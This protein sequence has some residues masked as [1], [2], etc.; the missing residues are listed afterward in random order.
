MLE[1]VGAERAILGIIM[2][3]PDCLYEV[4]DILD[5]SDFTNSGSKVIFSLMRDLIL[6]GAEE[7]DH[8]SLISAAEEKGLKDF[9]TL[10][11]EGGLLEAL[12]YTK[13]SV[14]V[15]TLFRHVSAV[16]TASIKR[17]LLET[18]DTLKDEVEDF[19]GD[20]IDLK[21]KV[22]SNIIDSIKV[23]DAG[24]DDIECLADNFEETINEYADKNAILGLNIDLPRWQRDC[25]GIKNGTVTGIFARAKAGK[26]QM[27]AY[28][29]AK[30]AIEQRLPILYLD[31]ELQL[32]HQQM[33]VAGILTGIKYE[34]I[35]SGA[36]KSDHDEIQQLKD[37]FG[38]VKASPFY[39]KNIAGRSVSHVIP[40]IRKFFHKYVKE[41]K[42]DDAKC[43]VIYDYIKLMN[44][45]DLKTAQ[46]YQVLG[47]LISAIHDVASK[48]NIPIL[49]LGQLNREGLRI[50]SEAA[51]AGSD[52]ITHN[53]DSL[54]IL[55]KK[56]PEELQTDGVRRGNHIL[57]CVLA[58]SGA[59]HEHDDWVNLHFD[60]SSGQFKEDKR[61][62]EIQQALRQ[63]RPVEDRL[64]EMPLTEFG[65]IRE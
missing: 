38:K 57:K 45:S 23:M 5:E 61:Q 53:V 43:L 18:L 27:A 36:W 54:T 11:H 20:A 13:D 9:L 34:R 10:T 64:E 4:D 26:S 1:A 58:R 17:Q 47:F 49:L 35:E 14:N 19:T 60:K 50:D 15:K 16:K 12:E 42:G 48:L 37:A 22:E 21:N 8:Y 29:A 62:L 25:G 40:V 63:T 52:R 65:E 2:K 31:T 32:R 7:L 41:S 24:E 46:E 28:A 39:Y 55:R 51:V 56:K 6:S 44:P 59:G 33:R 30:I 3:K